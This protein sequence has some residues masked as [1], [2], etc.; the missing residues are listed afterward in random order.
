MEFLPGA[1]YAA[2]A[3]AFLLAAL[4]L[5]VGAQATTSFKQTCI[6]TGTTT[7]PDAC[8]ASSFPYMSLGILLSFMVIAIV[9]MLGNV[10]NFK[11]LKDWYRGELWEAIKT[12]LMVGVIISVL[13]IMSGVTDAFVGTT[14][15]Q[16]LQGT[17]GAL[18]TNLAYLYN[19]DNV[20][21]G[22]QLNASYQAYAALLGLSTGFGILK[23]TTLS[24]WVPIPL[25][26]AVPPVVFGAV[27]FGST[28]NL[29]Q[30]NFISD[31]GGYPIL[32]SLTGTVVLPMLMF[33]QF[34]SSYFY[35]IVTLG[36][37]ILIPLGIIFRAFPLVR[38]I[39]GTLIAT[40]IGLALVYP[41]LLL[42]VNMPVSNYM[43]AFSYSQTLSNSC[44]FASGLMCKGWN[45]I[46]SMIASTSP[47]G[48]GFT[49]FPLAVALGS[50]PASNA[51]IVGAMGSGFLV[52][53]TTPLT[54]GIFPTLNFITDNMLGMILQ[55]ILVAI[56]LL[57]GLIITGAV[58]QTLGGKV[59]L[60]IGKKLSLG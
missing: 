51:K 40:G 21:V 16:P 30:S 39:G 45:A 27:Q 8:I 52:G 7:T 31:A 10:M 47:G 3:L 48:I 28:E 9:Y 46:T 34:Q 15:V 37:G 4:A 5:P 12:L 59:K 2:L 23:S 57:V 20:Y 6:I 29:L 58:T 14:P 54:S 55:F 24:L 32:Q 33:F 50:G 38:N 1:R 41:C 35:Y 56:D 42:L 60:G 19:A 36:L 18:S 17:P 43:Y 53:L 26:W 22:Q 13:V 44:P 49:K 11:T 25:F